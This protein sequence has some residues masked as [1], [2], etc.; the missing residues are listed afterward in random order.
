MWTIRPYAPDDRDAVMALADRLLVGAPGWR[1]LKRWRSAVRGWVEGSGAGRALLAAAESLARENGH[2]RLTLETG[3]ANTR[4]LDF[5][6]RAGYDV[7]TVRLT[8][9]LT[10]TR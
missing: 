1:D 2:A 5:Y 7:E 8:K 3:A 9:S 4:A 6:D 10:G